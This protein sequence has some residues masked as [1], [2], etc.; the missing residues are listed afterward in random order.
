MTDLRV[1]NT[2]GTS[3]VLNG[4]TIQGRSYWIP[5]SYAPP[6][7]ET[8]SVFLRSLKNKGFKEERVAKVGADDLDKSTTLESNKSRHGFA[9]A[10]VR[11]TEAL[12]QGRLLPEDDVAA[13]PDDERRRPGSQP[14]GAERQ[15]LAGEYGV[16]AGNHRI[17]Q[18]RYGPATTSAVGGFHGAREPWPRAKSCVVATSMTRPATT[19]IAPATSEGAI[20][21]VYAAVARVRMRGTRPVTVTGRMKPRLHKKEYTGTS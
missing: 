17:R 7:V 19:S 21:L 12:S 14:G 20:A 13:H 5:G 10:D 6:V 2:R 8:R 9:V 15:S 1:T 11:L 18:H 16:D 3:T 4:A